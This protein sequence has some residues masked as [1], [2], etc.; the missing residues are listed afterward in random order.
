[1]DYLAQGYALDEFLEDFPSV[2][3]EQAVAALRQVEHPALA[4]ALCE[5]VDLSL[6][7]RSR[8]AS[9]R[10]ESPVA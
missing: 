3:R 9:C 10:T 8:G 2:T 7:P 5:T 4:R 6:P 1:M